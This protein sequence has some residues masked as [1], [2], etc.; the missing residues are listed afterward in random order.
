MSEHLP[1]T[2]ECGGRMV[3]QRAHGRLW[4]HCEECTPA[5]V[6]DPDWLHKLVAK[7]YR[8]PLR[9]LKGEG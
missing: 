3:Y 6:V 1:E 8:I 4:S 7:A 5:V 2:C 9:Y